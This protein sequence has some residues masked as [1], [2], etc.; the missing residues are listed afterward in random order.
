MDPLQARISK[1]SP[2]VTKIAEICHVLSR[3]RAV[4]L[5]GHHHRFDPPPLPTTTPTNDPLDRSP[6]CEEVTDVP[7]RR[8]FSMSSPRPADPEGV[9]GILGGQRFF[10]VA[11]V[12]PS[13]RLRTAELIQV[14]LRCRREILPDLAQFPLLLF[15]VCNLLEQLPAG[16]LLDWDG[17]WLWC[18]KW[19]LYGSVV[20]S[21][22]PNPLGLRISFLSG[23]RVTCGENIRSLRGKSPGLGESPL[24]A[25]VF[26]Y[27]I[28]FRLLLV[29]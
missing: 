12:D 22:S 3:R 16:H 27:E 4:D 13:S 24:R 2:K 23:T 10:G 5:H 8:F 29:R 1:R 15:Q 25:F 28:H 26:I 14:C 7:N 17:R 19:G 11:V 6:K 20:G 21:A 18:R 9:Q